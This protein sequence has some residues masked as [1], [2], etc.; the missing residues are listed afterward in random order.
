MIFDLNAFLLND[1]LHAEDFVPPE[2]GP[3]SLDMYI[4]DADY[5]FIPPEDEEDELEL[6][7]LPHQIELMEDTTSRVLGLVSGYGAGKTYIATRKALHLAS[8]NPGHDGI[9]TEPNFPLLAQILIPELHK[10]LQ[11]FSLSYVYKATENIFYVELEDKV[12]RIICKSMEKYDRLIGINAAWIIADEFDTIRP[13]IAYQAFLKLLGR[14]RAGSVRQFVIT[15]TPEGF[16]AAY[17][18]FEVEKLGHMIQANTADNIFLPADF[19][20]ML[21]A[22]YP[23]HLVD[24]YIKGKFVNMK[25]AT[26]FNHFNRDI[27]HRTITLEPSDNEIWLGGD[28]NAGGCVTLQALYFNNKVFVFGEMEKVDT[29]ATAE[30]LGAEYHNKKL[31]GCFDATGNKKTS[32]ASR[33]DI[34]ILRD[35]GVQMMQGD[36]NPHIQDSVL[37]VNNAFRNDELYIDTEKCPKLMSALEQHAYDEITG[38]PEKFSGPGTIDDYTDALRYL[39]WVLKPVAKLS[40]S[41]YTLMGRAR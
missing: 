36:S 25:T 24:A 2:I 8:L 21:Y 22:T 26:V 37:A 29:F 40:F 14:L 41:V 17:R 16:G 15:T 27:H 13:E 28:F 38:D 32:N 34:Q 31:Y 33:S 35:V 10:A 11:E 6:G 12:T 20:D 9:I 23:A 3:S 18:I 1:D 5:V 39:L 7:L 30:A 19:I 4:D